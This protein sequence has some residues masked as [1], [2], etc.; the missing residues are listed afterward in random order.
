MCNWTE[1]KQ[2][3]TAL[4]DGNRYDMTILANTAALLYEK[5]DKV[6]WVGFYMHRQDELQL[7]PFQGKVAC[8]TIPLKKGVCG[9]CARTQETVVVEDVSLFPTHIACDSASKSEICIPII[10]HKKLYAVLDIDAPIVNRFS[11]NDK[12]NLEQIAVILE[13]E[14][15]KLIKDRLN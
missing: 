5:L 1:L 11:Q 7:G 8:T 4:I 10:C 13:K 2:M 12:E 9:A 3:L 14:L 6:N 15:E